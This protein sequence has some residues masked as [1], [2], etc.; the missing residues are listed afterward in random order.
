MLSLLLT[1]PSCIYSFWHGVI[2]TSY[3]ILMTCKIISEQHCIIICMSSIL[4]QC[5]ALVFLVGCSLNN[6]A[7]PLHLPTPPPPPPP[8]SQSIRESVDSLCRDGT[9]LPRLP[10]IGK[11]CTR[12]NFEDLSLF[13]YLTIVYESLCTH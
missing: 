6:S 9:D 1:V 10:Y 7:L 13:T 11:A 5:F 8:L 2:P 4:Q 12:P 3:F